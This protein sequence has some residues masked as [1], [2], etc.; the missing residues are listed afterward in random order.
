VLAPPVPP[1]EVDKELLTGNM[2]L[3]LVGFSRPA[4][5]INFRQ[6]GS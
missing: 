3:T 4:Q 6:A 5:S 1:G 2:G